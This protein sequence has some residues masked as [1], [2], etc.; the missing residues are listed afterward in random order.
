MTIG[1]LAS[2]NLGS[3]ILKD[4]I[5]NQEVSLV[6]VYTD[7][8]STSIIETCQQ[9]HIPLFVGNPRSGKSS[10][11]IRDVETP[12]LLLSVNYLFI[13]Q[14]DVI[15]KTSGYA[16]NIHGSLLPKFRGRT[17]HVWAIINNEKVT[18]VTAHIIEE[19]CDEGD[20]VLQKEVPIL[21]SYTGQDL[22]NVFNSLYPKIVEEIIQ[23][24]KAN[25]IQLV[26]QNNM[27]AT[28]FE[29]RTADDGKINFG[30]QKERIYNWVR[31]QARPYPGAFCFVNDQ[32][33]I[34]HKVSFSDFGFR[35][36][37]PNGLVVELESDA[38]FVK[39][40]NGVLKVMDMETN[41][42]LKIGDILL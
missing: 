2:G 25:T 1:L 33:L 38:V 12:Q 8:K 11:F 3:V 22:L 41:T 6:F 40:Q 13:I 36:D 30:W 18:G 16:I 29:K 10:D 19:G 28:F 23:K 24:V 20:I 39:T 21:E 5:A 9:Q 4:L 14:R 26:K 37:M 35:Q 32:K 34:I 15:S 31:A 42:K 17:P 27:N 7:S